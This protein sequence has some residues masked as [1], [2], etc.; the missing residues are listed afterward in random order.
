MLPLNS[1]MAHTTKEWYFFKKSRYKN[2]SNYQI[3]DVILFKFKDNGR[4]S[5]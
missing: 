3:A 1:S 2:A 5:K 4:N